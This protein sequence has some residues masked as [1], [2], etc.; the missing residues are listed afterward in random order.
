MRQFAS[1]FGKE[2]ISAKHIA[3]VID[4]G[5][6]GDADSEVVGMA[7]AEE[8]DENSL[9]VA[10]SDRDVRRTRAAVVLT[11]PRIVPTKKTLIYCSFNRI[12]SALVKV[13]ELFIRE[14]IYRNYSAQSVRHVTQY[15]AAIGNDVKLGVNV[16]IGVF[17]SIGS[18]VSIGDGCRIES[19]VFI[20]DDTQLGNNVILRAG[21]RVGANCLYH[22]A[23][24]GR[25]RT[26]CGVGRTI[27]EDAVE[28]GY[29][30]VIQRGTLSNTIIG[31]GTVIG[32]MVEIAHDVKL[33]KGCFIAS[34]AGLCGNVFVGDRVKIFGQAGVNNFV[35]IGDEAIVLAKT[36]VTKN[37]AARATVSGAHGRDHSTELKLQA[38]IRKAIGEE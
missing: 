28:I 24:G 29:N 15:G 14:G 27:I 11:E 6:V 34:Q 13:A 12:S 2:M 32:N 5:I 3:Q 33:G 16:K 17:A 1:E 23:E 4:G 26:F 10:F 36:A 38:R 8:A 37:V 31:A 9:A 35:R 18:G 21:A 20:G 30:S 25:R 19:G 7:Y 22:F